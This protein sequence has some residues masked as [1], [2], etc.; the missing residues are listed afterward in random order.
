M[1]KEKTMEHIAYCD[2]K[3][4]ELDLLLNNKKTMLVRGAAGRKLPYGRVNIGECVY[5]LENDGSGMILAKGEIC[6]VM[7]SEKLS[8]DKSIKLLDENMEKLQLSKDQKKRWC[9]KKYLCFIELQNVVAITP[10]SF[11][12]SNNM[13]D[14]ITLNSI[15][16]VAIP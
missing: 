6:A 9:G 12:R 14:W 8:E 4:E 10:F 5:L 7:N 13:D 2:K 3:A 11:R 1:N 15:D 16:E